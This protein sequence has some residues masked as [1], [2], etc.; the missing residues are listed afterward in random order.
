MGEFLKIHNT[1]YRERNLGICILR[2][3]NS[4]TERN[5]HKSK[6]VCFFVERIR[7]LQ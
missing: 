7:K 1:K 3:K 4:K 6:D 5:L 2:E